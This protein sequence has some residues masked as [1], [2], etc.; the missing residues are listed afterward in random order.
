MDCT[1]LVAKTKALRFFFSYMQKN[2]FLTMRL[3]NG[4]GYQKYLSDFMS[5]TGVCKTG[6]T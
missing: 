3:N 2:G 1:F 4:A 5:H 6:L